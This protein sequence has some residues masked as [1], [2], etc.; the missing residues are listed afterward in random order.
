METRRQIGKRIS[1]LD[2]HLKS[3]GRAKYASDFVRQD[4]L[5]S[6]LLT[7]PHANAKIV[8]IDVDDAKAVAGVAGVTIISPAGTQVQWEGTEVAIV[9]ARTEE[10][11][12][13]AVRK[14][15]IEYQVMPHLVKE[16]N[17]AKA[18]PRAK[19]AGEQVTG[20]PDQVFK[21]SDVVVSEGFYSMPVL[22]HC[23]LEPHGQVTEWKQDQMNVWPS[24]QYISGYA[25]DLGNT[26]KFA[27][28]KIHVENG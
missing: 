19:A 16:E 13:D 1:R 14:I 17:L 15:K 27:A 20:D 21:G 10:I 2:G 6:A 3:S 26:L 22:T 18:G 11:A 9:A 8:K 5:F 12:R 23:C 24:S 28:D 25:S 7:S 4:L